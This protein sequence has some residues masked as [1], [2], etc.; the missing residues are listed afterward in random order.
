MAPPLEILGSSLASKIPLFHF[1]PNL[2]FWTLFNFSPKHLR[3]LFHFSPNHSFPDR[4]IIFHPHKRFKT[5]VSPKIWR[6]R[7]LDLRPPDLMPNPTPAEQYRLDLYY[8][9]AQS[10]K[11]F[12]TLCYI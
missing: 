10:Y 1:L 3:A 8:A 2:S 5:V 11:T 12:D 6:R 4:C 7:D 9:A